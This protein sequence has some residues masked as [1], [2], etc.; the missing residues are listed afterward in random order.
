[1]AAQTSLKVLERKLFQASTQDGILEIQIGCLL[2]IFVIAP[3][4]SPYLGDFWSSAV[5]LPFWALVMLITRTIRKKYLHPRLGQIEYGSYRRKRLRTVNI[6]ILTINLAALG[7]GLVAFFLTDVFQGWI[8]LAVLLLIGFSLAGYL[9]ESPRFYLYGLLGALAPLTG[10]YL[11][12]QLGFSHHGFPF[13]FGVLSGLLILTGTIMML[14]IC[15]SY[16]LPDREDL[17]W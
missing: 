1:M 2:L 9:V 10:E 14:A 13:T 4:L 12:R 5:F 7:L 15:R 16:P 17:E 11:Y 6:A 3:L 8:P